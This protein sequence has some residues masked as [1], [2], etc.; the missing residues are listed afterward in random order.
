[1]GYVDFYQASFIPGKDLGN[2]TVETVF[3]DLNGNPNVLVV[4]ADGQSSDKRI[5]MNFAGSVNTNSN[6]GI[7]INVY[8][9]QTQNNV[10][11]S[12]QIYTTNQQ[13]VNSLAT[14][15]H[16]D[17]D[18]FW[19]TPA[20]IMNGLVIGQVANSIIGPAILA[21]TPIADPNAHNTSQQVYPITYGFSVKALFSG[22]SA[23][24]HA[25]LKVSK[26]VLV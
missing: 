25:I 26:M 14:N 22:S 19:N 23:G 10:A 17:F 5:K 12:T 6:L 4:P 15:W 1:M 13:T 8:F 11:T 20:N 18:I 9:V 3:P 24:N 7:T 16:L 21:N 2:V